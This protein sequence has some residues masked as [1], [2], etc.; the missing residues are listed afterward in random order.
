[1]QIYGSGTKGYANTAQVEDTGHVWMAGSISSMP[2]V[3]ATNESVAKI[4][5]IHTGSAAVIAG[6]YA[7]SAYAVRMDLG[8]F[9]LVAGS[10]SSMPPVTVQAGSESWI[11]GGSIHLYSGTNYADIANRVAGSIVNMPTTTVTSTDLDIRDLTSASDSVEVI[12]SVNIDN[13]VDVGSYAIQNVSGTLNVNATAD[14]YTQRID[15]D[16][17]SPAMPVYL[18]LALPGTASNASG[19]QLK[20]LT[21]NGLFVERIEFGSGNTNFDKVWDNRSGTGEVYS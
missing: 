15:A 10:I 11:K 6:D 19:W 8:S 3:T 16:N 14:I 2:P 21:Y 13:A 4:D 1:M 20:K 5:S 7:D 12:G 17:T 18:G 9:V